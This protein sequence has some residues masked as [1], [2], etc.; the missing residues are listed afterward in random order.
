[1]FELM[2]IDEETRKQ[3]LANADASQ[4]ARTARAKGMKTLVE[5]GWRK[6][7]AGETTP[8]ERW[9]VT[10]GVF[11]EPRP[12]GT[13]QEGRWKTFTIAPRPRPESGSRAAARVLAKKPLR[14]NSRKWG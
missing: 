6:V 4:L 3:I 1:I 2:E 7:V 8:Q 13:G 14:K 11:F 12:R 5:D 10:P 9:G